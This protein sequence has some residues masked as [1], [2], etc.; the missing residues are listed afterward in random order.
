MIKREI[1]ETVYEYDKEGKLFKKTVVETKEEETD[2]IFQS[3]PKPINNT[4]YIT[5]TNTACDNAIKA[6]RSWLSA[7]TTLE[8]TSSDYC[9]GAVATA[10][11]LSIYDQVTGYCCDTVTANSDALE[12]KS[13]N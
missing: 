9:T 5:W 2:T 1:T 11:N 12:S 7:T 8:G 10:S 3:S 4:P 6:D 13:I